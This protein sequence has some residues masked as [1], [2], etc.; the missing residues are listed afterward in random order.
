MKR[1][2][3]GVV[4]ALFAAIFGLTAAS[5]QSSSTA[6][7]GNV[8]NTAT[9]A[10][11]SVAQAAPPADFGSPPTGEVPILY[12]DHHVYTKP[13]ELKRNRVLAAL[14]RG[15]TI[16]IPLRSMFEQ[17]GATV[18][19][20]PATKTADISKPGSDVKV[21]VGKPE[22][23]INGE[24][25][26]LDVPPEI[27]KGVVVVPVR[28]ISEGMG[29]YVLW[30]QS[31][32]LVVVRYVPPAPPPP[33][34]PPPPP[35]PRPTVRPTAPPPPPPPPPPSP[36]PSPKGVY[37]EK[38]VVGDYIFNPKVYNEFS[39]GNN[40][41]P[42]YAVRA[43]LEFPLFNL[44][45]M[46]EGDYRAWN[47]PHNT[48]VSPFGAGGLGA[49][50][51]AGEQGCVTLPQNVINPALYGTQVFIPGFL[52]QEQDIDLRF[53]FRVLQPR[54]YIGI[55]YLWNLNN[56]LPQIIKANPG[57][58]GG[59]ATGY[60]TVS[61]VGFGLEKLPDLDQIV[62]VF[63]N[64]WYYP[65]IQ[66]NVSYLAAPGATTFTTTPLS[67]GEIKYT[68]G[69]T[70]SPQGMPFFIELGYMGDQGWKKASAPSNYSHGGGF[71]GL[72]LHF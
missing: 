37:Y 22:V 20:D 72:G 41:A 33:P 55:G 66:G 17:M 30:V 10:S 59:L 19:Y 6:S 24:S 46:I 60:P 52:N 26:P 34:P 54:I 65:N 47:Y 3:T 62:S 39:P 40:G 11:R 67:Y 43:A 27:Y 23:V 49:C 70:F 63:G 69:F 44:P 8:G 56:T 5:A 18:S 21:T 14:V 53:G 38:F 31:K 32:N 48:T 58:G 2:S 16:Y 15:N 57:F 35:T 64:A 28:V 51:T 45:W 29:A 4:T 61:G 25:R 7:H 13:D 68:A 71:V 36:T 42:S 12:N 50:P 1:I 9:S